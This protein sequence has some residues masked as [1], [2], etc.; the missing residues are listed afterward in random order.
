MSS[1]QEHIEIAKKHKRFITFTVLSVEKYPEQCKAD[2][3]CVW[4]VLAAYYRAI[5]LLEAIFDKN[6]QP[7]A[8]PDNEGDADRRR[9]RL[10]NKLHLSKIEEEYKELRR[11]VLHAKYLPGN[12]VFDYD[13]VTQMDQTRKVIV[14]GHLKR[15][16]R[17]VADALGITPEKLEP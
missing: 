16:E 14:D 3:F 13:V 5:H 12:S 4:V 6:R 2:V 11:L 17:L 1:Q 7:H 10:F 8:V 15:I 9:H